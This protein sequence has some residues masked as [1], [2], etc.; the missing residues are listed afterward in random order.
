MTFLNMMSK[1]LSTPETIAPKIIAKTNTAIVKRQV[2]LRVGQVTN[3]TSR[4]EFYKV[5]W[6]YPAQNFEN[7][8][9]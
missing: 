1:T 9:A 4:Q 8:T 2:S 6:N 5:I 3:L 7:K